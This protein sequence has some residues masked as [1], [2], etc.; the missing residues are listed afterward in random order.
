[1]NTVSRRASEGSELKPIVPTDSRAM[2][3]RASVGNSADTRR[4]SE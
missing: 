2:P 4:H 3:A 1:M